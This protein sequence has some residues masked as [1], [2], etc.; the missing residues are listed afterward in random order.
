MK[1]ILRRRLSLSWSA[2]P[3][4]RPPGGQLQETPTVGRDCW[5]DLAWPDLSWPGIAWT[6][7]ASH[8]VR[9]LSTQ[10]QFC[11]IFF[12]QGALLIIWYEASEKSSATTCPKRKSLNTWIFLQ[13]WV[14][15]WFL[16]FGMCMTE[17]L[18]CDI[19]D[20]IRSNTNTFFFSLS[21]DQKR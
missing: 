13:P 15:G 20:S 8:P 3:S 11:K 4:A 7:P 1:P 14:D 9:L 19:C 2:L 6:D 21:L 10:Q 17:V 5:T 18:S 12:K 16:W